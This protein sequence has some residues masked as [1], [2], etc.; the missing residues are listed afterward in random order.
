VTSPRK[1]HRLHYRRGPEEVQR[2][3]PFSSRRELIL[4]H[5]SF[6]CPAWKFKSI[7]LWAGLLERTGPTNFVFE[8]FVMFLRYG[9][10]ARDIIEI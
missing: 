1:R 7:F 5:C 6:L 8:P 2:L 4:L 3:F 10:V 9:L